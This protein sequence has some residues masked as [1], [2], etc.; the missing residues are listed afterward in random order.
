MATFSERV[1]NEMAVQGGIENLRQYREGV[2]TSREYDDIIRR[3]VMQDAAAS[4]I[5]AFIGGTGGA[6]GGTVAGGP[7]GALAGADLGAIKGAAAGYVASRSARAV[8]RAIAYF[9]TSG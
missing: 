7:V 4:S 1:F 6:F 2:L 8:A 5:G 9:S 3:E